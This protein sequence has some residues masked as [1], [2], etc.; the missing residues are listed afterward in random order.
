MGTRANQVAM[1]VVYYSP[2]QM[3]ADSPTEYEKNSETTE[4]ISRIPTVWDQTVP[5]AG[6]VGEYVAVARRYG[7]NWYIGVINGNKPRTLELKLDFLPEAKQFK[8]EYFSDCEKTANNPREYEHAFKVVNN[9]S[10]LKINL[11]IGG[12]FAGIL[13][14]LK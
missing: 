1:Y 5:L 14:P 11:Q 9:R 13:T 7:R 3:L 10:V 6:K 12:G 2:L 4:F 8:L